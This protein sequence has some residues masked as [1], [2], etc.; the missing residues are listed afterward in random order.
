MLPAAPLCLLQDL[1]AHFGPTHAD[2]PLP[3]ASAL[4]NVS[5]LPL[6]LPLLLHLGVL[7]PESHLTGGAELRHAT[8]DWWSGKKADIFA[9]PPKGSQKCKTISVPRSTLDALQT[10]SVAACREFVTQAR[11]GRGGDEWKK[12]LTEVDVSRIAASLE[13]ALEAHGMGVKLTVEEVYD[14]EVTVEEAE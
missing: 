6:P 10:A 11:A 7:Q 3:E 4:A 12:G 2:F 5:P 13:H 1:A 8:G 9:L 14:G